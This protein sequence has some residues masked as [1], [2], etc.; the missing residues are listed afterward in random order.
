MSNI[1]FKGMDELLRKLE[2]LGVKGS[3]IANKA[4]VRAAKPILES[5]T[6]NAPKKTGKGKCGIKTSRPVAKGNTKYVVIGIDKGD[7]SE[8]YYMK[9]HEFGEML[10]N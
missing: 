9:F 10:P 3:K 8:V 2:E 5:A 7:I 6:K 4:L 1:E